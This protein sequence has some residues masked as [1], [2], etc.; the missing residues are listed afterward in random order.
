[1][2]VCI[3][4]LTKGEWK[5]REKKGEKRGC[6]LSKFFDLREPHILHMLKKCVCVCNTT[7]S[8]DYYK[9]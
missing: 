5:W 1:M 3:Y 6:V 9:A 2:Y 7:V 8:H 4:F